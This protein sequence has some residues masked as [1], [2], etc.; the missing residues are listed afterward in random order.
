MPYEGAPKTLVDVIE[1]YKAQP[2]P[3]NVIWP[4]EP[5]FEEQNIVPVDRPFSPDF[6]SRLGAHFGQVRA[7]RMR[8]VIPSTSHDSGGA[9]GPSIKD[10][11]RKFFGGG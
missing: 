2:M 9:Y 1:R 10:R 8:R 4:G 11:V 6:K 3:R 5:G 7:D